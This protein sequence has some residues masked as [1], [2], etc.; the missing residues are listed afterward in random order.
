[1]PAGRVL[2]QLDVPGLDGNPAAVRHRIA[3]VHDEVDDDLLELSRVDG[4]A[5]EF[6]GRPEHERDVLTDQPLEHLGHAR[7][8]F[9]EA[10]HR[11]GENLLSA[12]R[13][14]LRRQP[15][16]ARRRPLDDAEPVAERIG[17]RRLPEHELAVPRDDRQ[18]VVEVVCEAAG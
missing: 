14:E 18:Q 16:R 12:E 3:G 17:E 10:Q 11:G 6:R 8:H 7:D 2:V 1:M 4:H 5:A 9:V 13:Q 15:T